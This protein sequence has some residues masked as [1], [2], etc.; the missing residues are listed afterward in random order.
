M[1]ETS[2][3]S[4][5]RLGVFEVVSGAVPRWI[6]QASKTCAGSLVDLPG[7]GGDDRIFQQL[8]LATMPQCREG[9]QHDAVLFAIVQKFPFRKVRMGF[10]V[11]DRRLDPRGIKDFFRLFQTDVG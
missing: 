5:M 4:L 11:N 8:G 6:A 9:L 10:D 2:K 1:A 3:F 7:D